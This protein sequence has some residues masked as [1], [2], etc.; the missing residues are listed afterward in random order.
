MGTYEKYDIY[1]VGFSLGIPRSI[2]FSLQLMVTCIWYA[3][4][5][6]EISMDDWGVIKELEQYIYKVA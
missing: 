2:N 5:R 6:D 3:S 1:F 4:D